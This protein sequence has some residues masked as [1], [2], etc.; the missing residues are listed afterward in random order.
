MEVKLRSS[1]NFGNPESFVNFKKQQMM[2]KAAQVF[3]LQQREKCEIR[4]DIIALLDIKPT[5]LMKH[6]E[7]AF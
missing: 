2:Y 1:Q 7:G 3:L 4:F 5:V 6:I